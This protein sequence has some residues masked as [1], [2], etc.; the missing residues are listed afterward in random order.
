MKFVCKNILLD[1]AFQLANSAAQAI[2]VNDAAKNPPL[3][4]HPGAIKYYKEKGLI[5]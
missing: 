4:I 1:S 2:N 3:P 5:K